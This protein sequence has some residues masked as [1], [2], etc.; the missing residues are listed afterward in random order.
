MWLL[1]VVGIG[2]KGVKAAHLRLENDG[3]SDFHVN[4]P[5]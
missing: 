5:K 4:T 1:A 3:M 2:H